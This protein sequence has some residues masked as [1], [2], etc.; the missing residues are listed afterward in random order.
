MKLVV[1]AKNY[2]VRKHGKCYRKALKLVLLH[3]PGWLCRNKDEHNGENI[4]K[5]RIYIH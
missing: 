4:E 5:F 2:W 3:C 1:R